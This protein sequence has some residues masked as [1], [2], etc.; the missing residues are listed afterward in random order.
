MVVFT[1]LKSIS[2]KS[3]DIAAE[4]EVHNALEYATEFSFNRLD[5]VVEFPVRFHWG[6]YVYVLEFGELLQLY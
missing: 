4:K 1:I 5:L 6:T 3:Q 2:G